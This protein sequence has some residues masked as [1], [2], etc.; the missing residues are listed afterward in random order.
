[1]VVKEDR[2]ADSSQTY[3][4]YLLYIPRKYVSDKQRVWPMVVFL[5]GSGSGSSDFIARKE[6]TLGGRL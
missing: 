4:K 5:H 2:A 3:S 1:L 6:M